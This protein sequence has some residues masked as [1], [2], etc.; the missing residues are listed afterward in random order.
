MKY[1]YHCMISNIPKGELL[2]VGFGEHKANFY[3]EWE[4]WKTM[5]EYQFKEWKK[6]NPDG[7]YFQELLDKE[8]K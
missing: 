7:Y 3:H 5:T 2:E 4:V 1:R 8:E 6:N